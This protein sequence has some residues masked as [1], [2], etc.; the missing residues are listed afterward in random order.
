AF[1]NG[2]GSFT[3][4]NEP[5]DPRLNSTQP[6]ITRLTGDFDGDGRTDLAVGDY[7][8]VT[9]AL[10]DGNGSFWSGFAPV[11]TPYTADGAWRVF[12]INGDGKSDLVVAACNTVAP[13]HLVGAVSRSTWH[14]VIFDP[15]DLNDSDEFTALECQ[16]GLVPF[17][18]HFLS[19]SGNSRTTDVA[20]FRND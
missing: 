20:L 3:V 17:Q 13:Q 6:G 12:D 8:G 5:V 4:T 16:D 9:V 2:N 1:S 14:S 18:G 7:S 10:S 19:R 11:K 15:V